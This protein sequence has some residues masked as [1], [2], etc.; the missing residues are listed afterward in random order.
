MVTREVEWD[1]EERGLRL[2]YLAYQAQLCPSGHYLPESADI[3]NEYNYE[4][5]SRRCHACTVMAAEA[6][7]LKGNAY[8]QALLFGATKRWGTR[9]AS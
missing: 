6:E 4:G 9:G 5:R 1:E 2:A 8:P 7:R 3:D